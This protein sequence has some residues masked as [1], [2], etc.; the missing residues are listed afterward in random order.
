MISAN[1]QQYQHY[2]NNKAQD[3]H[4]FITQKNLKLTTPHKIQ[5]I[6]IVR[7]THIY[8]ILSSSTSKKINTHLL[9]KKIAKLNK[10]KKKKSPNNSN[11][12]YQ[13]TRNTRIKSPIISSL[14]LIYKINPNCH[15]NLIKTKLLPIN[16]NKHQLK[17]NL[18]FNSVL[19]IPV[20]KVKYFLIS[21]QIKKTALNFNQIKKHL[22]DQTE[23]ISKIKQLELMNLRKSL[24]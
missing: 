1:C 18:S 9:N 14:K 5:L 16:S 8:K 10:N 3:S 24:H 4:L 19:S 12:K 2:S 20:E 15:Q 21:I 22:L 6:T 17:A 11:I 13:S 23:S 7:V